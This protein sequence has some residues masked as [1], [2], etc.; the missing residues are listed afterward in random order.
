[1]TN[2]RRHE[3]MTTIDEATSRSRS[4]R[5]SFGWLGLAA[6]PGFAL[7]A[8]ASGLVHHDGAADVL[9]ASA[10]AAWSIGG[11][12]PMYLLMSV[13]HAAPWLRLMARLMR[14]R[15]GTLV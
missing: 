5:G 9:C 6:T 10:H 4:D 8:L 7:M 1:M 11:M 2:M 3:A 15:W 12:A 13:F 14:R